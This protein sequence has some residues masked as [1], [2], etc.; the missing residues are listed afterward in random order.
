MKKRIL[1]ALVLG[2]LVLTFATAFSAEKVQFHGI[3]VVGMA[4]SESSDGCFR[5]LL[6][7]SAERSNDSDSTGK[8]TFAEIYY[9][10]QSQCPATDPTTYL[11]NAHNR[12]Q[13]PDRDFTVKGNLTSATLNTTVPVYDEINGR[14]LNLVVSMTWTANG[15]Q[16]RFHGGEHETY[17]NIIVNTHS[18]SVFQPVT[19]SGSIFLDG[20]DLVAGFP[21]SATPIMKSANVTITVIH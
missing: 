12:L 1:S 17:G 6:L 10:R 3:G 2:L 7:F 18:G 5:T 14:M 20:T 21:L 8:H 4:Y 9:W 19:V 15:E 11:F 16:E 13:I